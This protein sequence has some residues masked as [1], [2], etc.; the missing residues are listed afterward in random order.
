VADGAVRA[1]GVEL[2]YRP[3]DVLGRVAAHGDL[4]APHLTTR[5]PLPT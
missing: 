3:A 2:R 5:Q 1:G 4:A